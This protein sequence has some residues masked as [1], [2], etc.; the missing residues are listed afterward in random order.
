MFRGRPNTFFSAILKKKIL[1]QKSTAP[2][3]ASTISKKITENVFKFIQFDRLIE[4]QD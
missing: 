2:K 1:L 4:N 3:F